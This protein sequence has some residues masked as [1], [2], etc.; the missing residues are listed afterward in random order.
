MHTKIYWLHQFNSGAQI[1]IM[2]RPRGNDWLEGEIINLRNN[3]V[4][5]VVSLLESDEMYELDLAHEEELCMANDMLYVNF[6]VKDRDVPGHEGDTDKL[7][8]LLTKKINDGLSVV[9]HCRM[10]IGRSSIIAGAIL[11]KYNLKVN[12]I[13]SSVIKVRGVNV[14]DTEKQLQWLKNRE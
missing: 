2:A 10:G 11:V 5:I 14:P 6:P 1:G 9:V 4:D 13:I 7:I 12:D 8:A 3:H